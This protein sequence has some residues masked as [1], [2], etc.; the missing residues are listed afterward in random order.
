GDDPASIVD[1]T[2]GAI[3]V[4]RL[5]RFG[6]EAVVEAGAVEV[7]DVFRVPA[8]ADLELLDPGKDL[9]DPRT[10]RLDFAL[11]KRS[12]VEELLH[13]LEEGGTLGRREVARVLLRDDGAD[14]RLH[15]RVLGQVHEVAVK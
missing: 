13:L 6:A 1:H 2:A 14:L 8:R 9:A 12:R 5:L 4:V 10:N 3:G 11:R 15:P 7:R